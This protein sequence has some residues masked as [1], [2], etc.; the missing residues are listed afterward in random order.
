MKIT[1]V[2]SYGI[3]ELIEAYKS[4]RDQGRVFMSKSNLYYE[5]CEIRMVFQDVKGIELL[6]LRRFCTSLTN[7]SLSSANNPFTSFFKI[8]N[9]VLS[10]QTK[11]TLESI[12]YKQELEELSAEIF[13]NCR[14]MSNVENSKPDNERLYTYLGASDVGS[15][16]FKVIGRFQ[17]SDILNILDAF[18][19]STLYIEQ[20]HEFVDP[21]STEFTNICIKKFIANFFSLMEK[22][23]SAVDLLTDVSFNRNYFNSLDDTK[24]WAQITHIR[25]P[26]G[27]IPFQHLSSQEESNKI[28]DSIMKSKKA[29]NGYGEMDLSEVIVHMAIS[30]PMYILIA[31]SAISNLV[32]YYQ[33]LKT[34]IGV[35]SH[36]EL[37]GGIDDISATFINTISKLDKYRLDTLK[38][39]T[40]E[41]KSYGARNK[42][43]TD[44]KK[45]H[46][47]RIELYEFIPREAQVKFMIRGTVNELKNLSD[48]LYHIF[49]N[50]ETHPIPEKVGTIYK[51]LSTANQ[52]VVSTFSKR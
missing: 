17:G 35:N 50:N 13:Q 19:E 46:F 32:Y 28:C 2:T 48:S 31:I 27:D 12:Q 18:P 23:L 42:G 47:N 40:E 25:T 29:F 4:G 9:S 51:I 1:S 43:E 34:V 21:D 22:S 33:D 30:A 5:N 3:N 45:I 14:M 6:I 52:F 24:T 37:P 49:T 38:I 11:D 41:E 44:Y 15:L 16:R 26:Y 20:R 10:P 7:C 8:G 36:I 39:L